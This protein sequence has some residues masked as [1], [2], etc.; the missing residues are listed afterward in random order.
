MF[1]GCDFHGVYPVIVRGGVCFVCPPKNGTHSLY[2]RGVR[3]IGRYHESDPAL[4]PDGCKV[5]M[6]YRDPLDRALS[7]FKDIVLRKEKV[8]R[9]R[10]SLEFHARIARLCPTFSDF[11]EYLVDQDEVYFR[12][13]FWWF[14]RFNPSILIPISELSSY[15]GVVE[16]STH[17]VV[18]V[19][20]GDRERV[21]R[22]APRDKEIW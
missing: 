20:S 22:W 7:F 12:N 3:R 15:V 21:L 19:T 14:E 9:S 4:V 11:T 1:G 17:D 5:A 6:V 2:K 10:E 8:V 13:Q 18:D 16:H